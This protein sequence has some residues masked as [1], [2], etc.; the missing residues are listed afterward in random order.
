[1]SR[2]GRLKQTCLALAVS[3]ALG[4]P[5]AQA[6]TINVDA[7]CSLIEAIRE[8]E[9]SNDLG[10]GCEPAVGAT[11]DTIV[12]ASGS[13]HTLS[14][15][16]ANGNL[17][18]GTPFITSNITIQGLGS[19]ATIE[20]V[21]T[22][23]FRLFAVLNDGSL[24]IKNSTLTG[25]FLSEGPTGVD[26]SGGGIYVGANA[27]LTVNDVTLDNNQASLG[28]GGGIYSKG[29]DVVIANST[30]SDNLA[31]FGGGVLSK[32]G[33]VSITNSTLSGN[34]ASD[35]GGGFRSFNSS[36]SLTNSTLSGNSAA[37]DGGGF[38]SSGSS[39]SLTNSTLSGN[40]AA[41]GGGGFY[42]F[43][44]SISLTN[45]TLSGNSAA[46]DGGGFYSF[47]GSISL[48]NNTLSS[49][50][51]GERGGGIYLL[52]SMVSAKNS[53][54]SGNFSA[55]GSEVYLSSRSI[56][57]GFDLTNSVIGDSS[58]TFAEALEIHHL[59]FTTDSTN[60]NATSD[61]D[62]ISQH[63]PISLNSI[64]APLGNNGGRTQTHALVSG[65]PA[66]NAGRN[67][68]FT[69]TDQRG[70]QRVGICDIGAFEFNSPGPPVPPPFEPAT[71]VPPIMLLLEE[72]ES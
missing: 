34:S 18:T 1:M 27:G 54:L 20:R 65:S 37:Y 52:A 4:M 12:L 26:Y 33:S 24:T 15:G 36:I 11:D 55:E 67:S 62:G 17:F 51:A 19:G 3:Q 5:L 32:G 22:Q 44:A 50:S 41:Y 46:Y 8:A 69:D 61:G 23:E 39:I 68:I 63:I 47:G 25:G 38:N 9:S 66:I 10:L 31:S 14:V 56:V 53:V 60:I 6:V 2:P 40:S 57:A 58:K 29:G 43:Y 70:F 7:G 30:L 48:T 42:S 28:N 59:F 16:F 35:D 72:D 13:V 64:L 21:S 45:S 71:I 49:N